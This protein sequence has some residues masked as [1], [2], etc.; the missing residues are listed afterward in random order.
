MLLYLLSL[1]TPLL[2]SDPQYDTPAPCSLSVIECQYESKEFIREY[3]R[4]RLG[5]KGVAIS[6]CE[7]GF[8]LDHINYNRNGSNDLGVW[9]I[10]SI[11][12]VP[13]T[14]RLDLECSTNW[15]IEKVKRDKSWSA[16]GCNRLISL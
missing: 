3:I 9:Q 16:W 11:H 1:T 13:D 5:D 12:K 8:H 10:N 4:G 2:F 14:C 7:S 15:T 6:E